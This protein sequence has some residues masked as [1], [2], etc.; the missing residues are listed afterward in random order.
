MHSLGSDLRLEVAL[1]RLTGVMLVVRPLFSTNGTVALLYWGL[2]T[3]WIAGE[4]SILVRS[5]F[6]RG[7]HTRDRGSFLIVLGSIFLGFTI[8]NVLAVSVR[9]AAIQGGHVA[10]FGVGLALMAVGI[11]LRFY[12]VMVLGRF[13]TPVVMVG[14]DQHVVDTGPYRWIRHPSYT[15][16]LL[17]ITGV[18]VAS[19]NWLALVGI[20]PALA[21]LLY[22]IRVEEQALSEELGEPYRSYMQRTKRLLPFLY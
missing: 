6:R 8:A 14:S 19:A 11:A 18:L 10:V 1:L 9:G 3:I 12:A 7:A 21:G 20:L 2:Y 17:A 16:V 15:G 5:F 4:L 13:F 22:R